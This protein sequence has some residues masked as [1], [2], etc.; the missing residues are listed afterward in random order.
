MVALVARERTLKL[1]VIRRARLAA[2][3]E[4]LDLGCGTGTL[5]LL[6]LETEPG[7]ELVGFDADP[8]VLSR[9]R[10]KADAAGA[11]IELD[12]GL[13]TDLPYADARFDVVLSTLFFHHLAD[14]DKQRTAAEVARVLKPGGRLV[15]ADLGRPHGAG[16]R[17]AARVTTQLLDGT[18]TTA[19]S[20]AGLLPGILR[21]A[22]LRDVAVADR[23]RA[24]TGTLETFTAAAP[25]A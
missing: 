4:V 12:E 17:V 15:V 22:G 25:R 24:P 3:E 10:E 20:V 8:V 18:A 13:S 23:L 2:G 1:G 11:T 5:A 21:A 14:E 19:S 7:I 6:A 16:M 9:A